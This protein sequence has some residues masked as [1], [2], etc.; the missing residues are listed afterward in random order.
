MRMDGVSSWLQLTSHQVSGVFAKEGLKLCAFFICVNDIWGL[1]LVSFP[2]STGSH[3]QSFV[4]SQSKMCG[5]YH[6]SL[7]SVSCG[8]IVFPWKKECISLPEMGVPD[9]G[10]GPDS[11]LGLRLLRLSKPVSLFMNGACCLT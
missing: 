6:L 7:P 2:A 5:Y 10:S 3:C 1:G 9:P 11:W 8:S 4:W